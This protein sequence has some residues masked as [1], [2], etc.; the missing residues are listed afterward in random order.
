MDTAVV[1]TAVLCFLGIVAYSFARFV[2]PG[3]LYVRGVPIRGAVTPE[4]LTVWHERWRLWG[5]R[6]A[7]APVS[8]PWSKIQYVTA[9]RSRWSTPTQ[10]GGR[11]NRLTGRGGNVWDVRFGVDGQ[12]NRCHMSWDEVR[13]L[14][15]FAPERLHAG[16]RDELADDPRW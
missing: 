16:F 2:L 15:S 8:Y 3:L 9:R 13:K 7:G 6:S 4:G 10:R 5:T 11:Y 14:Q 12:D 1:L